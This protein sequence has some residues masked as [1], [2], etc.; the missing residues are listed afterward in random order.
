MNELR[1]QEAAAF[2]KAG[3]LD[4]ALELLSRQTCGFWDGAPLALRKQL[5][6]AAA[7]QNEVTYQLGDFHSC[8]RYGSGE[9]QQRCSDALA[10]E[11]ALFAKSTNCN[12]P[13]YDSGITHEAFGRHDGSCLLVEKCGD[14]YLVSANLKTKLTVPKGNLV[15]PAL[16]GKWTNRLQVAFGNDGTILVG[17]GGRE[18]D[19]HTWHPYSRHLYKL[20]GTTLTFVR[21]V[22]SP[23]DLE[24]R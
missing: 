1:R 8:A 22:R 15:D 9:L 2:V 6:L 4:A 21:E 23:A 19:G 17:A 20:D 24:A 7:E 12:V 18:Y 5:E 11:N 13:K 3:K 10:K 14:S 16:C